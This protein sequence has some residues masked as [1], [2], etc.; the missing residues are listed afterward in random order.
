VEADQLRFTTAKW[1]WLQAG[2]DHHVIAPPA[3]SKIP[4]KTVQC[5]RRFSFT[6]NS[7]PKE[8]SPLVERPF[9]SVA[10]HIRSRAIAEGVVGSFSGVS[11]SAL[12]RLPGCGR[13]YSARL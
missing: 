3:V 9:F 11:T 2:I 10:L 4:Q 5:S 8:Q 1:A 12:P 7:H 13:Q 6:L